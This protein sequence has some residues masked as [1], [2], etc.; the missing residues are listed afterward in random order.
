MII[1]ISRYCYLYIH[2]VSIN[3]SRPSSVDNLLEK[4]T[5]IYAR[6][7]PYESLSLIDRTREDYMYLFLSYIFLH[8][9]LIRK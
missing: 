4:T 2:D 7:K 3:P 9:P 5:N 8:L 6:K 1:R